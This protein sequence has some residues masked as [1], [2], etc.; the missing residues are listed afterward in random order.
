[1]KSK[2]V[3][4][5]SKSFQ[6]V[7]AGGVVCLS[8]FFTINVRL[9]PLFAWAALQGLKRLK[10]GRWRDVGRKKAVALTASFRAS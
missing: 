8:L 2:S 3:K 4:I 6:A 10:Y 9:S 1:M 5:Y 7:Q